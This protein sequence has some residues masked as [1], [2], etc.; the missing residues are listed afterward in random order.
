M[1]VC[2]L[3]AGAQTFKCTKLDHIQKDETLA[4][5]SFAVVAFESGESG[6]TIEYV[7][8]NITGDKKF[9]PRRLQ[10]GEAR[11]DKDNTNVYEFL[12]NVVED[13]ER[14]FV[15]TKIGSPL[16]VRCVTKGLAKGSRVTYQLDEEADNLMRI[17]TQKNAGFGVYPQEGKGCVEISTTLDALD[18]ITGWEKTESRAANGARVINVVVN[19]DRLKTLRSEISMLQTKAKEFEETGDYINLEG[20]DSLLQAK[21]KDMGQLT[22]IVLGGKGIKSLALSVEDLGQKEKRRYAVIAITESYESLITH[23]RDMVEKKNTHIDY[24]Y[25]EAIV[26]AYDKAIEHKDVPHDRIEAL[27]K[28]RNDIATLRKQFFLMGRAQELADKAEKEKGFECEAVY[29]NLSARCKIAEIIM[30]EHPEIE[31]VDEIYTNTF[32]RLEKHPGFERRWMLK[33]KVIKGS[34][35]LLDPKGMRV[36]AAD[37]PGKIKEKERGKMLG[38]IGQNNTFHIVLTE[39]VGYIIIEG[40]KES[41]PVDLSGSYFNMGTLVLESR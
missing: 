41:R 34:S 21:E 4:A 16:S 20:V 15:I 8:K 23:A 5:K 39:P 18:I 22:D 29:K 24:G 27:Q 12:F 14:T 38:K 1:A 26:L 19:I 36:F 7:N 3:V 35:Y 9:S 32:E 30:T 17:E 2:T 31:G 33:G 28:E 13:A 37:K 25:Y 40:E 10:A 6:W 11:G